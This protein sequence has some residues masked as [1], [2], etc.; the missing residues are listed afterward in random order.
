MS[1]IPNDGI[2]SFARRVARFQYR[3]RTRKLRLLRADEE[4]CMQQV[5][6]MPRD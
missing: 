1:A 4:R 5:R 3:Q 2:I 6:A